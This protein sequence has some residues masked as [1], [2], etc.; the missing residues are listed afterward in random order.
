MK[1]VLIIGATSAMAREVARRYAQ[2][3]A[4]LYLL[5]RDREK[6]EA[7]AGD[8][9]VRGAA[10]VHTASFD[11]HNLESHQA[12]LE[13]AER[14]LG[15]IDAALIAHGTLPDQKACQLSFTESG[16]AL[17]VNLISPIAFLTWLANYF[18]TRRAGNITVISSVA[19]DRGR[20]S[21]YIYGAAKGG[22]TTFLQGL[23]NRLAPCGVSVTT[24]KPGFVDTPMTEH[25]PKGPLF[26]DVSSVGAR[27]HRAMERGESIVYTPFFWRFIMLIIL[28]I[29]EFI[30]KK[31]KL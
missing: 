2:D 24:I 26:A 13:S 30:F 23:R 9:S 31:M 27:I 25:L 18:E 15:G 14:A 6:L 3:G 16:Q 17:T 20:Q 12:L 1:K 29:P 8:L 11:A 22:L 28:H 10:A 5:A 21:N 4:S 7:L 19:G